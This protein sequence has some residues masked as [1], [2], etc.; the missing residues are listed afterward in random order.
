MR[1]L[2]IKGL[3]ILTSLCLFSHNSLGLSV[4][5]KKTEIYPNLNRNA[6]LILKNPSSHVRAFEIKILNRQMDLNKKDILTQNETDFIVIPSQILLNANSEEIVNITYIGNKDIDFEKA[7]RLK[8]EEVYIEFDEDEFGIIPE[9]PQAR[10]IVMTNV[11]KSL[12]VSNSNHKE[13]IQIESFEK[14]NNKLNIIIKNV[15]TKRASF[16]VDMPELYYTITDV[17]NNNYNVKSTLLY[18]LAKSSLKDTVE[19]P[20]ELDTEIKSIDWYTE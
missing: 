10:M 6:T 12:F 13:E 7:F 11:V 9:K 15:G 5:L 1:K 14:V 18:I 3:F 17:N 19:L 20:V 8:I 4:N 16:S 2:F